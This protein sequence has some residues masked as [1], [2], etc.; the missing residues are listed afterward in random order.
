MIKK[1]QSLSAPKNTTSETESSAKERS[2]EKTHKALKETNF[3]QVK[4]K[5]KSMNKNI[6]KAN[7]KNGLQNKKMNRK[8]HNLN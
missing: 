3:I 7:K 1:F 2:F 8:R 5:N 6:K 4:S